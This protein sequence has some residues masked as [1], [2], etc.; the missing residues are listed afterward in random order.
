MLYLKMSFKTKNKIK[1]KDD[2]DSR[3]TLEA[4]HNEKLD[5]FDNN[6]NILI[7][8]RKEL[9]KMEDKYI[10]IDKKK[11]VDLSEDEMKLKL[12]IT[13]NLEILK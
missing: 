9:K 13:D 3:V 11:N 10:F 6:R 1:K 4:K 8:K 7:K 12:S 2:F 5:T